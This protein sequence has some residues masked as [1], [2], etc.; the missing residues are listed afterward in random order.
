MKELRHQQRML[1]IQL[2]TAE[3][4]I[5]DLEIENRRT[6]SIESGGSGIGLFDGTS[7]GGASGDSDGGSIKASNS[8]SSLIS[9]TDPSVSLGTDSD[10]GIARSGSGGI[11]GGG[12]GNGG[13]GSGK[14]RRFVRFASGSPVRQTVSSPDLGTLC[15]RA[16]RSAKPP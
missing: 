1:T 16:R 15:R 13:G 7:G 9:M 6:S 8:G 5:A 3:D 10:G 14:Q 12:D 4:T 2:A 11:N